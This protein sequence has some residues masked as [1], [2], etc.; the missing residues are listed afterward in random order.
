MLTKAR[1]RIRG[2]AL[3][4]VPTPP[5]TTLSGGAQSDAEGDRTN[6]RVDTCLSHSRDPS[7]L[8]FRCLG[9]HGGE[10]WERWRRG[11]RGR[12]RGTTLTSNGTG[13]GLPGLVHPQDH[14]P[15]KPFQVPPS[16]GG[17]HI[18][19]LYTKKKKNPLSNVP[20]FL[21]N[22]RYKKNTKSFSGC[23]PAKKS[24]N[25][26]LDDSKGIW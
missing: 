22:R 12:G 9:S 25:T 5:V 20:F 26:E 1:P 2:T 14:H 3:A 24:P 4:L 21:V 7:K 15:Y 6:W 13:P 8:H 11:S 18:P 16:P 19:V 17:L 10:E 23:L